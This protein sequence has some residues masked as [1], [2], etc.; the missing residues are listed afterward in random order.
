VNPTIDG[1]SPALQRV[2]CREII[3]IRIDK[4]R[5]ACLLP[6]AV[7]DRLTVMALWTSRLLWPV[8]I[9]YIVGMRLPW[10]MTSCPPL[11]W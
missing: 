9:C 8:S 1:C 7:K 2:I 11:V 6:S 3:D 4:Q 5:L 10:P